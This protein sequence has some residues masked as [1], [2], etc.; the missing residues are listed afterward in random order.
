M[1]W[2]INKIEI[3]S[4][5]LNNQKILNFGNH[6]KIIFSMIKNYE[7]YN[8][9]LQSLN[10]N[11]LFKK[12]RHF[13]IIKS[14]T[15][16]LIINCDSHSYFSKKYF[17][18]KLGKDYKS[19]AYTSIIDHKKISS[20]NTAIQIFTKRGPL[21]FLPISNKKTS[22]VYSVKGSKNIDI[23]KMIAK[24]NS[25]YSIIKMNEISIFKLGASNLRN[26]Y[27]KN[28]LAFGDLLHRIH[29]F[30]LEEKQ[31]LL[32]TKNLDIRKIKISE[33]LNTYTFDQ[34]N[35]KTIQ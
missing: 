21:A 7:L 16:D 5:N 6:N 3:F 18:K 9:L 34:Y 28:I 29:P 8:F 25:K 31:A 4:D 17:N 19:Y 22:I 27:F 10:K 13:K 26:Y 30:T 11:K 24:Y 35:N 2:T 33:I 1:S 14:D 15:Y 12:K 32:E 23:N 20:N